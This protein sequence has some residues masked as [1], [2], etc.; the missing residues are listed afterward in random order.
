MVG[1][2]DV[3]IS[4]LQ[5]ADDTFFLGKA[6]LANV[7]AIEVMLRSFELV[8]GLKIN[9]AK[10]KFGAIGKSYQWVQ[11]ATNYLNCILLTAPFSYLG[12]PIGVNS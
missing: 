1:R 12:I 8:S 11:N 3:N 9:F 5:Y 7:K 6:M 4:L 2:N 10:S